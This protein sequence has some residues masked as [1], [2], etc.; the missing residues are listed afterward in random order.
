MEHYLQSAFKELFEEDGLLVMGRGLG[1]N[2]LY[3]K[4]LQHFA[5]KPVTDSSQP[6]QHRLVFCL[7][8]HGHE[9]AMMQLLLANGAKPNELLKVS[10]LLLFSI[11]N[12]GTHLRP[13]I[14]CRSS[15]TKS[16]A[17]KE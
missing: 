14:Y 7:N 8:L 13:T 5:A 3:S 10:S 9:E 2:V 11:A 1:M 12:P 4:F 15:I 17:M 16:I 6:S